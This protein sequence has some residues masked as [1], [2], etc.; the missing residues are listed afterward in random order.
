M[1][2]KK[3]GPNFTQQ[4]TQNGQSKVQQAG[5]CILC[6]SF[7]PLLYLVGSTIMSLL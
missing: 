4:E 7:F 5:I 3:E 1:N 2:M 6:L